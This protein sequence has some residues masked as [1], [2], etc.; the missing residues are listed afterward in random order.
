MGAYANALKHIDFSGP[1]YFG[2]LL[3]KAFQVAASIQNSYSYQILLI[4][5]DG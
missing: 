4:L 3:K 5:T 2:P 1:T